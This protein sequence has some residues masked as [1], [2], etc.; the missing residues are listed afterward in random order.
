MH[1]YRTQESPAASMEPEKTDPLWEH[2]PLGIFKSTDQGDLWYVNWTMARMYGYASAQDMLQSVH[3]VAEDLFVQAQ[4]Y[5]DIWRRLLEQAQVTDF[6]CSQLRQNGSR[7]WASIS[8]R[9]LQVDKAQQ[10]GM[11]GY[12]LDI[13]ERKKLK[14]EL[15]DKANRLQERV[16]ELNCIYE[17][18]RTLQKK[19]SL[20]ETLQEVVDIIPLG[21]Q[22][23]DAA[24]AR[25][26]LD[27]QEVVSEGFQEPDFSISQEILVQDVSRG[28]VKVG[29]VQEKIEQEQVSFLQEEVSLLK[30]IA[31][32]LGGIIER[33]L[34]LEDISHK[35]EELQK[36]I[37]E[38]DQFF[39]IIAHD[40]RSPISGFLSLTQMMSEEFQAFSQQE[41]QSMTWELK[42]SAQDLH[43]LLENLL[44]W[45]RIQ[46]GKIS[47]RP[48]FL[49][50]QDVV[51]QNVRLVAPAADGKE[52]RIQENV[53]ASLQ[54]LAD[55]HMLD[56]ILRNLLFNA[57]KFTPRGGWVRIS[58][59]SQDAWL[60][61]RIQDTGTGMEQD[62][63]RR[64]FNLGQKVQR[65]GTEGEKGSGLGLMLCQEFVHKHA[66]KI[67]VSSSPK[68]GSTFCFTLPAAAGKT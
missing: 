44:E 20:Q 1:L 38:K 39:S 23:S 11:L 28:R 36:S 27:A 46:R 29:Y 5:G 6:E 13:T 19:A 42:N 49:N 14:Q 41:L 66:G 54:V 21:L 34:V 8:V 24:C 4:E 33:K 52:V 12:V 7:F 26:D 62:M 10:A 22:Y 55:R 16:K 40:L 30:V 18:S 43:E 60:Q 56:C 37:A 50:L 9:A 2:A 45:S 59:E 64:L 15:Q 67:W 57:V 68:Q 63:V 61:I 3:N 58:A 35:K 53:P 51:Q 48:Q 65:P 32:N 17:I 47:Y 31:E 25:I